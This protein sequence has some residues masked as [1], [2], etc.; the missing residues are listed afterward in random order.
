MAD[1]SRSSGLHASTAHH[2]LRTLVA[3]GYLVQDGTT[4]RYRLGPKAF[5][6]AASGWGEAQLSGAAAP[7][8]AELA[9]HSGETAHLAVFDRG[10]VVVLNKVDGSSP[11]RLAERVGYPRPA[12]CTAIGKVLLAHLPE[13]DFRAFLANADLRPLTARTITSPSRLAAE[14]RRIRA[15]GHALDDEEFTRGIRCLAAPVTNFTG[16]VVAALGI[17]GPIWRVSRERAAA[18]AKVVIETADHLSRHLGG[19]PHG[20]ATPAADGLDPRVRRVQPDGTE[21]RA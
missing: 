13:R 7:F 18:I 12:H 17:S 6:V 5:R 16:R 2:L 3:L 9:R 19:A 14:L 10:E 8:L 11:V 21:R 20:G 15:R 1:V 4:R